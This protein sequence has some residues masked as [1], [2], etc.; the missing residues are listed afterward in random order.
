MY[1]LDLFFETSHPT[2]FLVINVLLIS[3]ARVTLFRLLMSD[4]I[5]H[6]SPLCLAYLLDIMTLQVV[7][8]SSFIKSWL[9]PNYISFSIPLPPSTPSY[10]CSFQFLPCHN[11]LKSMTSLFDYI[12]IFIWSYDILYDN[13][14]HKDHRLSKENPS[15]WHEKS[16]FRILIRVFQ[17]IPKTIYTAAV[18]LDCFS[19]VEIKYLLLKMPYTL[20][21]GLG[22]FEL[23]LT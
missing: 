5:P 6:L 16:P 20:N 13:A 1:L 12:C 8:F 7:R 19:E 11:H 22:R 4:S 15:S 17:V 2:P 21:M 3:F 18:D 10:V 14:L 23:D 9:K